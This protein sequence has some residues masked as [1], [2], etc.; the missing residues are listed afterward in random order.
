MVQ[1]SRNERERG[2]VAVEAA[3]VMPLMVA[4]V[5]GILQLGLISHARVVA[6]YAAYRAVRVGAMHNADVGAMENAAI[7][8]LLPVLANRNDVI[9]STRSATDVLA[10]MTE[11]KLENQLA[12][13]GVKLVKVVVCGPTRG[14]LKA[15]GSQPL[16]GGSA[17][18]QARWGLGSAN[19]VDFD[20][21]GLHVANNA[22]QFSAVSVRQFNRTRLRIQ[23]QLLYR[24]PIPFANWI[25]AHTYLGTK[26]PSLLMM[27]EPGMDELPPTHAQA[28][29]VRIAAA[30]D[31]Y[32]IPIN[33]GYAMRMQSNFFLGTNPPPESNRC[34]HYGN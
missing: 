7:L 24:M 22:Q 11:M 28:N 18:Q 4:M 9:T 8:H 27:G 12:V 23:V 30:Q 14:E 13:P 29:L 5:L 6:K 15:T 1:V 26:L 33:V 17:D 20:D 21:P 32:V 10:K 19:E 2:Q 16:P 25:I 34:I 3:L 31:V